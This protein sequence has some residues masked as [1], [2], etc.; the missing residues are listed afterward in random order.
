MATRALSKTVN[1]GRLG[2]SL[3]VGVGFGEAARAAR[4]VGEFAPADKAAGTLLEIPVVAD[5]L[6]LLSE[7]T[8]LFTVGFSVAEFVFLKK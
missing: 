8:L 1:G 6:E 3:A 2:L 5:A 4:S 7:T